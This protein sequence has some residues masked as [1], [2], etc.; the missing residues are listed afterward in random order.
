MTHAESPVERPDDLTADWLTANL[1]SGRVGGF[2][3][4]RIGTG[5]MSECYRVNLT[6]ADGDG[7]ASVVLKVAASDPMSRGTGQ[8]LGLY[9]REVRFYAEVAPRLV[10]DADGPVAQCHHASYQPETGVFSLLLDDA[11]PAEVGDE[12]RGATIE[13]AKLALTALGRLHA[14]LIGGEPPA[15]APWLNRETPVNQ[16]LI[17]GLFN[18]FADRYGEAMK[19]EQRLVCQKLV[20]SF[21]AY[22]AEEAGDDR[23]TGMVHGDYRLD[24]MLFG[25]PGSLRELTVVDWQTV[26]WGPA[27]TDVAY[28]LGCALTT[29]DRRAHYDELLAAYYEGLGPNPP[30][31]LEQ[32]RDG[33]RRQSFFGVMMAIV[34]SMLVARTERGDQMFLTMLD[35]HS[36]HVLDTGALDALP[37]ATLSEALQPD[38][39]DEAAHTPGE[40][41]LWSESWYWDFA[42]AKQGV[43]GWIRLGLVPNQNLAWI[44]ALICGPDLPTVALLDFHAPLPPDPNDIHNDGIEFRHAATIPLQ[45]YRVAVSGTAQLYDDPSALL[46]GEPGR[47]ADLAMDLVWNTTGTPYAY[48]IATRYEIPCTIS[49]TVTADGH[50]YE[51]TAV[52]GQRDHSHG[53]RDWWSMDWVWSALH[54]EDGTHLHGVDLRIPGMPPVSVGYIQPPDEPVVETTS[55]AAEATLGGDGLPLT[56]TLSMEP[57]PLTATIDI[58]GHAPVRLVAPDG[59]ISFFPRAWATVQTAD[60]RHG[61]GWLEWNTNQTG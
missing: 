46:R 28:F 2:T 37:V 14:P 60:G 56:T 47:P 24:N 7:P 9:E 11:A 8:A 43:G 49:G 48:R 54:L 40:E 59:R 58:R 57:G 10:A 27:M 55:V 45:Q 18:G 21:D 26:T 12:I 23:V 36:S 22:L 15:D 51:F 17:T 5:Q 44:N 19:P 50:S 25:R 38:P 33:V 1:G 31:S 35:R 32:V 3:V 53:V 39:A 16:A 4:E 61:V 42:D 41:P 30:V 29:E 52:P 20:D 13:D 34:S 6:Y